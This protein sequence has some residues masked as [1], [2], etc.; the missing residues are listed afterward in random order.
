MGM[1]GR[2]PIKKLIRLWHSK[3]YS[4]LSS[5]PQMPREPTD[6]LSSSTNLIIPISSN[7]TMLSEQKMIKISIWYFSIWK[8][9]YIMPSGNSITYSRQ[10]ILQDIHNRFIVYQIIKG[11]K[12]MHSAE[13]IHRDLKPSNVLLNS[14]CH[15]KIC[16]F[17]LARSLVADRE[18]TNIYLT[19]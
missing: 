14:D 16:D 8:L 2:L 11:I 19:E 12:F 9:I 1:S 17:G 10:K 7:S 6:K 13:L 15:L 4:M 5:I 18:D 3:K